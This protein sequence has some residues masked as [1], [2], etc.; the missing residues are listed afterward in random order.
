MKPFINKVLVAI[1]GSDSSINGA[2]YAIM[3]A[4][5]YKWD[6]SVVSVVDT[7]TLKELLISKIFVEE[8]SIEFQ[9]NLEANAQRYLNYIEEIAKS[10]GVQINKLTK[11]GSVSTMIIEA[12]EEVDADIVVLGAW[13]LNRS[14]RDLFTRAHMDILMD[15]KRSVLIV[16]EEDIEMMFKRF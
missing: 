1:S 12:A 16:K 13:Q 9:D 15:S 2:K 11:R 10:K 7:S 8:E 3:L 14:K 6:L 5:M 4:K